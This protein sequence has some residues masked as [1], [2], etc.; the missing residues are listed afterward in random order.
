M[1][2]KAGKWYL[3]H[4]TIDPINPRLASAM[5]KVPHKCESH[6]H[7]SVDLEEHQAAWAAEQGL[8]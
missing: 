1:K 8:R 3:A 7:H 4:R 5:A 2:T 6:A